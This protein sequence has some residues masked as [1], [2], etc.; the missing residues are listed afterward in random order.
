MNKTASSDGNLNNH[1]TAFPPDGHDASSR[2][3]VLSPRFSFHHSEYWKALGFNKTSILYCFIKDALS[4]S[5]HFLVLQVCGSGEYP[6][7]RYSGSLCLSS[8]QGTG[9]LP[10]FIFAW[11]VQNQHREKN[12]KEK[13]NNIL[14]SL[15][16]LFLTASM[17]WKWPLLVCG[18]Y[19]HCWSKYSKRLTMK[20]R[21]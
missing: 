1:T 2:T 17:P 14:V 12:K 11:S 21:W 16:K 3:S 18:Q 19:L 6:D 10:A 15:W 5:W 8:C 9:L 20:H 4:W 7:C 13:T